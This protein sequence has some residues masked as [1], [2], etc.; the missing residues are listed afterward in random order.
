MFP[1][2]SKK[3]DRYIQEICRDLEKRHVAAGSLVDL[4][5]SYLT[6]T[7]SQ[8]QDDANI[9]LPIPY[10]NLEIQNLRQ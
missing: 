6:N 4:A 2:H 7:E 10:L 8:N 1:N 9:H 5:S 3:R